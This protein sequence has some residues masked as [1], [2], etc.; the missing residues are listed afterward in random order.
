MAASYPTSAPNF[1]PLQDGVDYPQADDLQVVYDEVAAMGAAAVSGGFAHDLDPDS[2]AGNRDLGSTSK[3]WRQ[4]HG[5]LL[6]VADA[7][8]LTIAT[9]AITVT[10]SYHKVDTE[11]DAASDDLATI[12]AGTGLGAGAIVIVRAENVARVVTLKDGS[13]NLLLNGD[14]ALSATDRLI[15]L[16]YDGT[17][18][19]EIA[20]SVPTITDNPVRVLDRDVT[21]QE[22]VN[23]ASE[24]TVY[25]KTIPA[26]TLGSTK[27]L[28]LSLIGDYFQ[29]FAGSDTF[30]VRVKY[31]STTL[32]TS[33]FAGAQSASRRAL[34]V[35]CLLSAFNA[36]NAQDCRT[37]AEFGAAGSVAGAGAS[38]TTHVSIHSGVTEDSTGALA[39][40][41]TVQHQTADASISAKC[42]SAVLE[43]LD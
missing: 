34:T 31:G 15:A 40:A 43:L 19:R 36:T 35:T 37:T 14:F 30:T 17:N 42:F 13:G 32:H 25:T 18:W 38:P 12:T 21:V 9:G 5:K 11:A 39:L 1:T 27:Q 16:L 24:T 22:V 10:Q 23:S 4:I 20:R 2:T 26:G 3:Q 29:N 7:S 8:E 6:N 41:V 28:R 33:A